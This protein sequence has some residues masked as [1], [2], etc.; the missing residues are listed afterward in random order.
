MAF[1]WARSPVGCEQRGCT[2]FISFDQ[3]QRKV[4]FKV[5]GNRRSLPWLGFSFLLVFPFLL[6][7]SPSHLGQLESLPCLALRR[8]LVLPVSLVDLVQFLVWRHPLN[9]H[10]NPPHLELITNQSRVRIL[11]YRRGHRRMCIRSM[12]HLV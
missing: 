4:P 2:K 12:L 11:L 7:L 9:S 10:V 1:L 3:A 6:S 5:R 8:Y